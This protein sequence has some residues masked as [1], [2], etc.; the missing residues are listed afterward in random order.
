MAKSFGRES[1]LDDIED[2]F[3]IPE[4]KVLVKFVKKLAG[5]KKSIKNYKD[6]F[7][8]LGFDYFSDD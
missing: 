8:Y 3:C 2:D 4:E 6:W 7:F 1:F 5:L